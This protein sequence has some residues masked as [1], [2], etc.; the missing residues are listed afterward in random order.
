M[1]PAL[2]GAGVTW[3]H[4]P[5]LPTLWVPRFA[6]RGLVSRVRAA[7]MGAMTDYEELQ[8]LNHRFRGQAQADVGTWY[9]SLFTVSPGE[10]TAGTEVSG[11]A[12]ARQP[13][14]NANFTVPVTGEPTTTDNSL[15]VT[16]PTATAAWGTIV[17]ASLDDAVTAGNKVYFGNLTSSKVVDLGDTFRFNAGLLDVGVG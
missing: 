17:A 1:K 12:Y 9:V 3:G 5:S 16:Y 8:Y 15:I 2:V 11:G 4:D 6:W 7:L 14:T 13:I 10:A